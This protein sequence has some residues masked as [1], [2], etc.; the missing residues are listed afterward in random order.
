MAWQYL[1]AGITPAIKA[2]YLL[3][4][5]PKPDDYRDKFG[6]ETLNKMIANNQADIVNKTLLNQT[7]SAAKSLGSRLYQNTQHEL[8]IAKE[9]GLLSS[10]QHAQA[11]LSAGSDIQGK[12]GEQQQQALI[13][14]TQFTA[15]LKANLDQQR[16]ELGRI[17]DQA[18]KDY[19]AATKQ[20]E[21]ELVGVGMDLATVGANFAQAKFAEA[22]T[23][24]FMDDLMKE[25]PDWSKLTYQQQNGILLK[26]QLH[27]L[28]YKFPTIGS[29]GTSG[30]GEN[31]SDGLGEMANPSLLPEGTAIPQ[32]T[33]GKADTPM[34]AGLFDEAEQLLK[35]KERTPLM[36]TY[37]NEPVSLTP[38]PS[39]ATESKTLIPGVQDPSLLPS[40]KASPGITADVPFSM[41][42]EALIDA[43]GIGVLDPYK[44]YK[45][46][47]N[48]DGSVSTVRT[49]SFE[50]DGK[51]ILIPTVVDGVLLSDEEA[52]D[53]Y[54][55]TGEHFGAYDSVEDANV[56]AESIHN[57]QSKLLNEAN[58]QTEASVPSG[59]SVMDSHKTVSR[60]TF[61]AAR[62]KAGASPAYDAMFDYM[63]KNGLAYDSPAMKKWVEGKYK[64]ARTY[65][66]FKKI[67]KAAGGT[68]TPASPT[69]TKSD[70]S[71]PTTQTTAKSPATVTGSIPANKKRAI[72]DK[73]SKVFYGYNNGE[74]LASCHAVSP[75]VYRVGEEAA[76]RYEN[77][78]GKPLMASTIKK[79]LNKIMRSMGLGDYTGE[80]N[81]SP[82]NK[83][84]Y[85]ITIEGLK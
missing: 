37:E 45:P 7:T 38:P 75:G 73:Y 26:M 72:H 64:V 83:G 59:G 84:Y 24:R 65:D 18:A 14:N 81:I 52:I 27:Q 29:I 3:A 41:D 12:V 19:K 22:G 6:E 43:A 5:K 25:Y 31:G 4:N 40:T 85:T 57:I 79:D 8:D 63:E 34:K 21:A 46:L 74:F 67:Y 13:Q 17:K 53:H 80:I 9:K 70:V 68:G 30:L 69:G 51:E 71:K 33:Q 1:L 77:L 16:L 54:H 11:L 60:D 23:Q 56:A 55:K 10:G 32:D 15:G 49:M 82:L 50:E 66:R 48:P 44:L 39:S 78:N 35:S 62:K 58:P 2:G 61:V 76:I 20:W 42:S 36:T 28:G 47:T